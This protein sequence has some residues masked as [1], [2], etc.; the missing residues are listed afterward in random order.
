MSDCER[1]GCVYAMKSGCAIEG[2][3]SEDGYLGN[4][5]KHCKHYKVGCIY[6]ECNYCIRIFECK[7][8]LDLKD[9]E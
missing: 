2:Y 3:L 6:A 1:F 8:R 5:K 4:K 7:E 9:N